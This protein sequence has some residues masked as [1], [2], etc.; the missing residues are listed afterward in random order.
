ML[1]VFSAGTEEHAET[2][3][4]FLAELFSNRSTTQIIF[5]GCSSKKKLPDSQV[6][7]SIHRLFKSRLF[8]LCF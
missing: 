8:S 4:K 5:L 6:G 3:M 2:V 1:E 7:S